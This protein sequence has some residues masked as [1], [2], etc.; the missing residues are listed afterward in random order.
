MVEELVS[1]I[2]VLHGAGRHY[3][4]ACVAESAER[5]LTALCTKLTETLVQMK[6]Q[7]CIELARVDP[8]NNEAQQKFKSFCDAISVQGIATAFADQRQQLLSVKS[9]L[10]GL[11]DAS[12]IGFKVQDM[13]KRVDPN[14]AGKRAENMVWMLAANQASKGEAVQVKGIVPKLKACVDFPNPLLTFM[15]EL[16]QQK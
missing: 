12:V 10:Q 13:M 16:A 3:M 15:Q 6:D 1:N 8:F 4:D 9:T 14:D 11:E 5:D 7:E 2:S